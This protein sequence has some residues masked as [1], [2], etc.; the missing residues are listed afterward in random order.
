MSE[1][2]VTETAASSSK[3]RPAKK[4]DRGFFARIALF[5]RQVIGELKKVVAPTRKELI[6]YTLVV[7]VFVAIMMLIVSLL[8]IA[9]GTG[10]SWVFGGTGAVD[11]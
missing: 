5:V 6:N 10:A 9:F 3:G 7:L 4:A 11:Q 1:D 2:Q 8:D